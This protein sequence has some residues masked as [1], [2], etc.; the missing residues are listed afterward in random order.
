MLDEFWQDLNDARQAE[1]LVLETLKSL[2]DQYQFVDVSRDED[3]FRKGDIKVIDKEGNELYIDV[4]D[5]GTIGRTQNVL[6]EVFV[7]YRDGDA[8]YGDMYKDY[9]YLAIVSQDTRKIYIID[10]KILK[11]FYKRG[12]YKEIKHPYSTTICYLCGLWQ[13]RKWGALISTIDF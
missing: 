12:E 9:D 5:D 10:F 8:A 3:C 11:Q 13:I 6:C 7:E 1:Q 4:K 2:T